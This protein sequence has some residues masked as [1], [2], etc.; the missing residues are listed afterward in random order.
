MVQVN[1][2]EPDGPVESVAVTVTLLLPAVGRRAGDQAGRLLI[3]KPRQ[4]GRRVAQRAARAVAG[5]DLQAGAVSDGG[6]LVAGLVT[7]TPPVV[8]LKL[9]LSRA[10]SSMPLGATPVWPCRSRRSRPGEGDGTL[11]SEAAR[12]R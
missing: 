6:A 9:T 1:W 7:V 11:A 3:D 8:P 5:R 4:A 10:C 12:R 2:V